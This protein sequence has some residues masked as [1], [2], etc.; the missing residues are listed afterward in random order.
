MFASYTSQIIIPSI[1]SKNGDLELDYKTV[2]RLAS[3]PLDCYTKQFP[4][5][6]GQVYED[7]APA[8][9]GF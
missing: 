3:L 9:S 8:S 7:Q 5:E 1:P 4:H 2:L 6:G